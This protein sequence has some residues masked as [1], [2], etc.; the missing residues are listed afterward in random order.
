M[1]TCTAALTL[2]L[3]VQLSAALNIDES[4]PPRAH[5]SQSTAQDESAFLPADG[6][7]LPLLWDSDSKVGTRDYGFVGSGLLEVIGCSNEPLEVYDGAKLLGVLQASGPRVNGEN[8]NLETADGPATS[9]EL[10]LDEGRHELRVQPLARAG[11]PV[12]QG[13]PQAVQVK[14]V[15]SSR[16][17]G[18]ADEPSRGSFGLLILGALLGCLGL[19]VILT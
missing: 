7:W 4:P 1:L 9:L 19:A 13:A 18:P 8:C 17:I 15:G 3:A 11:T 16:P 14:L 5:D 10:S 12:T 2:S 6:R